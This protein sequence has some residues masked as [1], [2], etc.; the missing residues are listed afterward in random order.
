M[1]R[2]AKQE[3]ATA[4]RQQRAGNITLKSHR[5]VAAVHQNEPDE[6]RPYAF[7]FHIL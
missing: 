2:N 3:N 7:N 4:S 6:I 1:V 5:S